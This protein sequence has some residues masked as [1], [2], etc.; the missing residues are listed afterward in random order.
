[1]TKLLV[2]IPQDVTDALRLPPAEQERELRKELALAL[3]QRGVLAL[4]KSRRLAGLSRW[5]FERLLGER[6]IVR[7]YTQADLRGDIEYGSRR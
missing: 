7:H 1:M 6:K 4:G 5:E 3:Y 2:E